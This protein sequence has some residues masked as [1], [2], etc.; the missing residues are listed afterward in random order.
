MKH[1]V[2]KANNIN[3][4]CHDETEKQLNLFNHAAI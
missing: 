1:F 2:T 3:N 4:K